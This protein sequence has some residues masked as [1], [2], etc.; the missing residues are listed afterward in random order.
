LG[1]S[2]ESEAGMPEVDAE[3]ASGVL[4][5]LGVVLDAA[6]A[7]ASCLLHATTVSSAETTASQMVFF[8]W[9]DHGGEGITVPVRQ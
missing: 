6:D 1:V 2:V 8:M 3:G 5:A 7:G 9:V 4:D